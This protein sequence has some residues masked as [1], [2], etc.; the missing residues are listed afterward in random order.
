MYHKDNPILFF[1]FEPQ[2]I[3]LDQ[4]CTKLNPN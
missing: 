1:Y 3:Y 4:I 2:Q